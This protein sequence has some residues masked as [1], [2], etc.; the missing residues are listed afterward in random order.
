MASVI[1]SQGKKKTVGEFETND[2]GEK[3]GTVTP[4]GW[5]PS[6]VCDFDGKPAAS[7]GGFTVKQ[8][9]EQ[10]TSMCKKEEA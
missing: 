3:D 5:L 4:K 2:V 1:W 8:E 10:Y 7:A 6:V 9:S